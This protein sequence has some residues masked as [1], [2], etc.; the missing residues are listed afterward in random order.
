LTQ[1]KASSNYISN[2]IIP[3]LQYQ[4]YNNLFIKTTTKRKH[5]ILFRWE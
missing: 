2:S 4:T 1:K 3:V 5:F